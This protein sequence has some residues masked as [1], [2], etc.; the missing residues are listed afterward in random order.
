MSVGW[1]PDALVQPIE[2]GVSTGHRTVAAATPVRRDLLRSDGARLGEASR[3]VHDAAHAHV[4]D[5]EAIGGTA[6]N[7]RLKCL[8]GVA[9]AAVEGER[10][11]VLS[12]VPGVQPQQ[13][14]GSSNA[15][16]IA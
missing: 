3:T 16:P 9:S 2:D 11:E 15:D 12:L 5:D 14:V 6:V 10:F 13:E 1:V 4:V 8:L 7:E